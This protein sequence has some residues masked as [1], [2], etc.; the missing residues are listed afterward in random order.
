MPPF[1]EIKQ[2]Y[3]SKTYLDGKFPLGKVN[4][5]LLGLLQCLFALVLGETSSDGSCLLGSEVEWHVLLSLIEET[6]LC[7]LVCVDDC[8]D[9]CDGFSD[10]VTAKKENIT[11]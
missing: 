1:R 11:R 5:S 3:S 2:L 10:I 8:E 6:E 7:A 9:L 4:G